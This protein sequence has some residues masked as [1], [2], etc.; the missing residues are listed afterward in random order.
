MKEIKNF[1]SKDCPI[2]N[3]MTVLGGKWSMVILANLLGGK[4][5]YGELKKCIP[6][7]TEKMLIHRLKDL[8]KSKLITR[9]DYQENPPKV[10][11]SIS[12]N[13][14]EATKII[15]ILVKIFGV[16]VD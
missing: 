4:K 9:K 5:R 1:E 10:E 12:K 11:Y 13:G 7:V 15:P 6:D 8:E 14:L 16:H 3:G 2:R